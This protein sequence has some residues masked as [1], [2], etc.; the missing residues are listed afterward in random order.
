MSDDKKPENDVSVSKES[1]KKKASE[2][3]GG[4]VG[5][6]DLPNSRA[7][8]LRK[9]GGWLVG[10][11]VVVAI[12]LLGIA[13]FNAKSK[14]AFTVEDKTYSKAVIAVLAQ[15]QSNQTEKQSPKEAAKLIFGYFKEEQ[16]AKELGIAPSEA[17][18]NQER[19]ALRPSLQSYYLSDTQKS[20][21]KK[22]I[23]DSKFTQLKLP[24]DPTDSPYVNYWVSLKA[25]HNAL[26]NSLVNLSQGQYQGFSFA[27]DFSD[28]IIQPSDDVQ[29]VGQ[30]NVALIAKDDAYAKQ[31]ATYYHDQIASG[32]L[33]AAVLYSNIQKDFLLGKSDNSISFTARNSARIDSN[34]DPYVE[35][36]VF[37]QPVAEYI[38]KQAKKGLSNVM[39]AKVPIVSAAKN[40]Q[41]YANGAYYFVEIDTVKKAVPQAKQQLI[42]SLKTMKAS[43]H[44]V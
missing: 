43:Y 2:G 39:V 5:S 29:V 30:G 8:V 27:F 44:G 34:L 35:S 26:N 28:K 17:L 11:L 37:Y 25:Y 12:L 31:Q 16:A 1:T 33:T 15:I 40:P 6:V 4:F 13:Q 36:Q 42:E 14:V 22:T 32:K 18:I 24:K 19:E 3:A 38:N 41:D 9:S 23:S 20:D 21:I 7:A 10:L